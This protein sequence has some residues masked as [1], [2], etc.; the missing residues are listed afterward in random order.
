[1]INLKIKMQRI[2]ILFSIVLASQYAVVAENSQPTGDVA[3]IEIFISSAKKNI[4]KNYDSA[5]D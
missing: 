3:Q 2:I 5:I 1:M 4:Y